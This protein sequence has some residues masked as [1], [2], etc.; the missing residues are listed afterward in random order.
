MYEINIYIVDFQVFIFKYTLKFIV[1]KVV[2]KVMKLGLVIFVFGFNPARH[3]FGA[4]HGVVHQQGAKKISRS[5]LL[6]IV[7]YADD[8]LNE[9]YFKK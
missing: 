7:L 6:E 5:V 8:M 9:I 1:R 3:I 2:K 4:L